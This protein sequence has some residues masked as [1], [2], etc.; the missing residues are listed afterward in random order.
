[1]NGSC[2]TLNTVSLARSGHAVKARIVGAGLPLGKLA[3]A[4]GMAQSTLSCYLSGRSRRAVGQVAIA[5]AFRRLTG[6]WI[7]SEDFWGDLWAE[8]AA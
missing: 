6:N 5:A 3:R 4:A 1:M 7:T 2:K 8:T